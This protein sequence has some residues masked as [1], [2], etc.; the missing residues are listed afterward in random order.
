MKR[1]PKNG[2]LRLKIDPVIENAEEIADRVKRELADHAGIARAAS[3]VAEAAHEAR[4]VARSLQRLWGLHRL[5]AVF[6]AIA[7]LLFGSWVYWSFF[8]VATLTVAVPERDAT[9]LRQRLSK[10][11]RLR[12]HT[13]LTQGSRENVALLDEGSVDLAFVQGGIPIPDDLPRLETRKPEL[14]LFFVREHISQPTRVRRILTSVEGQGS[15]SVALA[16]AR[17]WQIE[18]RVEFVH[19]WKRLTSD[20]EYVLPPAVDAVFVIKDPANEKTFRAAGR[21]AAEGFRL[22]SPDLGARAAMLGYLRTTEISSAYLGSE[23]PIPEQPV[24][25]YTVATYLVAR[26]GLTPRRLAVAAHLSDAD[27]NPLRAQSFEPTVGDASELLQGV[28]AFLSILIYIGLAFLALLGI[29]ITTYRRRFHE[30]NTLISLISM[31]QSD[32]DV[33]GLTD[34]DKRRENLLYLS[35]CSD[36]LGLISVISGYYTQEN[37]SLL[38]SNLLEIIHHRCNGLKLNIQT[39]ILHASISITPDAAGVTNPPANSGEQDD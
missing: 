39:K 9:D 12:F 24:A 8:H 27:S 23:P 31:H 15:H 21:L 35:I 3:G 38:Y 18:D 33:L 26:R 4:R 37:S 19:D 16:F 34:D 14:V 7:L 13:R 10:R 5:P 2:S 25:T 30:L 6:L 20:A 1:R 28:E 22:A 32:K 17:I 36:L 11:D 29:E